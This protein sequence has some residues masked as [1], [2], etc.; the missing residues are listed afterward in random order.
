MSYSRSIDGSRAATGCVVEIISAAGC[1]D[2]TDKQIN[3][4]YYDHHIPLL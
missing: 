1:T 3:Q 2:E 4:K